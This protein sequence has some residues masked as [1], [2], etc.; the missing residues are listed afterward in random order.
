MSCEQSVVCMYWCLEDF[1][2][3]CSCPCFSAAKRVKQELCVGTAEEDKCKSCYLN[4][5]CKLS[6]IMSI[7]VEAEVKFL[8]KSK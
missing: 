8:E 2:M 5:G 3:T 6:S 4:L 7:S 1:N